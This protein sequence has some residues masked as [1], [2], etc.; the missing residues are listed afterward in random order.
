M[1]QLD[2]DNRHVEAENRLKSNAASN[3]TC[4]HISMR[5]SILE[6]SDKLFSSYFNQKLFL[7]SCC[8]DEDECPSSFLAGYKNLSDK[9]LECLILLPA[10]LIIVN[11]DKLSLVWGTKQMF[12]LT[13]RSNRAALFYLKTPSN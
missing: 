7:K 3:W 9:S 4:S 6:V 8:Q 13:R 5:D 11:L 2:A 12:S 1:H 10:E